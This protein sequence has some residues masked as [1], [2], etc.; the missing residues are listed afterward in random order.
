MLRRPNTDDTRIDQKDVRKTSFTKLSIMPEGLLE[1]LRPEDVRD[2][3][4][5]LKTLK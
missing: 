5:F 3:F 4:T 1:A 2:L